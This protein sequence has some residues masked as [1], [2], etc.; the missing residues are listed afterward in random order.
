MLLGVGL[1]AVDE[2]FPFRGGH[3]LGERI[4][5]GGLAATRRADDGEQFPFLD[6]E[7]DP[8]EDGQNRQTVS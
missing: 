6:V 2:D 8:I 7:V 1:F 4:Q 3:Q 5:E